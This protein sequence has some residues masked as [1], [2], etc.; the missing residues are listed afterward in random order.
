MR[1]QSTRHDPFEILEKLKLEANLKS[2]LVSECSDSIQKL[3][4][5]KIRASVSKE[6]DYKELVSA[7]KNLAAKTG[8]QAEKQETALEELLGTGDVWD[9][10]DQIRTEVLSLLRWK[11]IGAI[12]AE[13]QPTTP[14]LDELVAHTDLIKDKLLDAIDIDRTIPLA[15]SVFKPSS[16]FT[17]YDGTKEIAFDKASEGQRAGALLYML[18]EQ[19]G[20]PLIIDQPEGD[21]DNKIIS[22]IADVLHKA[23][24]KRQLLF[25]S[26]NANLVVNGSS[27]FVGYVEVSDDDKRKLSATGAIDD[28]EI[29]AAITTNMEGG[30]KAFKDRQLKYG[31]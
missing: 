7:L 24:E 22:D 6:G 31:F 26:H 11:I 15:A 30:E 20:G 25:V 1:S 10:L 9:S 18:L 2:N 28:S 16:K 13:D 12:K 21:L 5:N 4:G 27:E 3:S 19:E 23:K 8:S 29:C 17:Y 14:K